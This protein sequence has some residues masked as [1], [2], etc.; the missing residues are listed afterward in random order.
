MITAA[1]FVLAAG[2]G[3]GLRGLLGTTAWRTA[4]LNVVGS[5]VLGLISQWTG[6]SLTVIGVGAIGS[7]TT[8]SSFVGHWVNELEETSTKQAN[9][10]GALLLVVVS[11]AG[12]ITAALLGLELSERNLL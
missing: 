10:M 3:A 7:L 1:A 11:F 2:C 4:A 9:P 5:F 6:P 8:Y 12:G